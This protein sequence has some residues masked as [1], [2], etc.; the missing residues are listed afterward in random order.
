MRGLDLILK[1]VN[2]E[3]YKSKFLDYRLN[4]YTILQLTEN[5]LKFF[6]IKDKDLSMILDAIGVLKKTLHLN[7]IKLS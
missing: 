6:D 3:K 7:E 1:S 5:D 2:C 4:E